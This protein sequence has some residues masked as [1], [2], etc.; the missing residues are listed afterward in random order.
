MTIPSPQNP[1]A[2]PRISGGNASRRIA[3]DT[4]GKP[5]YYTDVVAHFLSDSTTIRISYRVENASYTFKNG[6]VGLHNISFSEGHGKLIGIMGASGA[7][8]TTLLNVLAGIE[9]PTS[10]HV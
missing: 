3:W 10:G 1:I 6:T 8:K 4:K 2:F 7:G 9:K 5:V